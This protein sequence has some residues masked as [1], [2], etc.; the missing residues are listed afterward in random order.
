MTTSRVGDV[1][2]RW[3]G[4]WVGGAL[5][6]ASLVAILFPAR[7]WLAVLTALGGLLAVGYAWAQAL[8][9]GVVWQRRLRQGILVVGDRLVE[10]FAVENHAAVPLLWADVR[11]HSDLPG[12]TANRVEAVDAHG[13]KTWETEGVCRRRGVFRLGP[14]DVV[15]GDPFG[16]FEVRWTFPQ[17]RTLVVYPR[18]VRLPPLTL[19][20]GR[21]SGVARER[22]H[23]FHEDVTVTGVRPYQPG[24]A[25]RRIHWRATAHHGRLMARLFDI[26]PSG[27][28]WL[29]LDLDG[30]VQAGEEERSTEEYMVVLATSL[31]ARL[32]Q[33]G[34]AVGG[35][36]AGRYP[37]WVPPRE[38]TAHLWTLLALLARARSAADVSLAD[39]LRRAGPLLGR[40]RTL[41]IFTP[42]RE[43]GWVSALLDL[44]RRGLAAS[45][46]WLDPATFDGE[47]PASEVPPFGPFLLRAHIPWHRITGTMPLEVVV[48]VRRRRRE[49]RILPGTGRVIAVEVE[50]EV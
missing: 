13:R 4:R 44:H 31:A 32:L 46:I 23:T 38:G 24:D 15:S 35:L 29:V 16:L 43:V 40:G 41:V 19:P 42:T 8:A 26:E 48:K 45:V 33:E 18:I 17:A 36:W 11:D 1:Q 10:E 27:D 21:A 34:R 7:M 2:V 37:A 12:Y 3:R 28:V 6:V 30:R 14:W 25:W 9:R 5:L 49:Y 39:L 50:E 20:R 22:R 47:G